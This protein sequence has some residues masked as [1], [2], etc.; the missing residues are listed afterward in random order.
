[1][2]ARRAAFAFTAATIERNIG[3]VSLNPGPGPN[4][5]PNPDQLGGLNSEAGAQSGVN[6]SRKSEPVPKS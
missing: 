1:M 5:A 6:T 4:P 2:Y 3:P